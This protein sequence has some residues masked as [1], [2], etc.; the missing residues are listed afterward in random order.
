MFILDS[1]V[2]GESLRNILTIVKRVYDI[3]KIAIPIILLII[4]TVDLGKAVIAADEKEINSATQLL[5]KRAFAAAAV[6]LL[7]FVVELVI[8]LVD[9]NANSEW[10]A[11]WNQVS[12][13]SSNNNNNNNGNDD[14]KPSLYN[15][16][17][18]WILS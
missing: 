2:C 6:F 8:G 10:K 17:D 5:V 7:A 18:K 11:C 13:G 14:D 12:G 9:P 3:L 4:G 16:E 15:I 1:A